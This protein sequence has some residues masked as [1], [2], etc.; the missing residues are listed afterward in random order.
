MIAS[1]KSFKLFVAT[2]A[3]AA[4]AALAG[5][6]MAA[7]EG[8]RGMHGGMPHMMMERMLER[9]DATPEQRSQI[10]QIMQS[11][12]TD[13]QSQREAGRTLRERAVTL[14]TQPNV[15]ANALEALRQ[16]ML[17]QHDQGSKRMMQAMLEASRV[18]TPQQRKQIAD[19]MA[20][21]RELMQRHRS[22]REAL[23]SPR[24]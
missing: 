6:A 23:G 19:T 2:A 11:A 18:L 5:G 14:F 4:A 22:E 3:V 7:P 1:R 9:V 16:Q 10:K 15:D 8:G 21:Q 24:S 20:K 13:M 12:R 17:T